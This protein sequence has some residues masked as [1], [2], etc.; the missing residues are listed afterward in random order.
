MLAYDLPR[1]LIAQ[2]P[3]EPRDAARLLVLERRS[4]RIS[5]RIFRDLPEFLHPG[6][7]LVLNDTEVLPARLR[8]RR[9]DTGGKVELLILR[10]FD[11]AQGRQDQDERDCVYGC[12]GQPGRRLREG[13]KLLFD[14][15]SVE[16]E[17]L[18]SEAGGKRVRFRGATGRLLSRLGEIPLPPYIKRPVQPE[19]ARWYQ[20]VFAREPGAVAA[21]TAGLHFTKGLME[22]IRALGVRICFVTLH[23]GWGTF[24]PVGERELA[25][26]RLHEEWFRVPAE[27]RG[28]IEATQRGGGRV[29]AV[30]TTVVRALE[31]V[32]LSSLRKRG[33]DSRFRGNDRVEGSTDLF[34]RPGF[35]FRV[36]DALV[37]NFHLP[38][39]SLLLLVEA[40]AGE[41][42]ARAAYE[43]AIRS[44]YR[45]YSYGDAVVIL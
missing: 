24:K 19:D 41:G 14:H 20:T 13:A 11:F 36:V 33:S 7:C 18:S 21:P 15:G 31:T 16:G 28:A 32:G 35:A 26:G 3:C 40:F 30:G 25:S 8:G 29:I 4:G 5:H 23:V 44:R 43:E 45:F 9:A 27:T 42:L 12:L 10:P 34:I 22:R 17:I 38:G 37:T 39:T 2:K 6:D 1:E